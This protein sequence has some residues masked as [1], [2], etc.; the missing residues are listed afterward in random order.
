[1]IL[2]I[3]NFK[4]INNYFFT[5]YFTKHFELSYSV[6][7]YFSNRPRI[8]IS[9]IF[10][11]LIIK[12]PFRNKWTDE[13]DPPK[14]G[15]AIHHN[16]FWLYYGG[17]GNWG[18]NKSFAW[19]IPFITKNWYRTS[20]LLKNGNWEHEKRGKS[21]DFYH[22]KWNDVKMIYNYDFLDKYDNSVVP[23]EITVEER[24]WRP[25]WLEW[26]GLFKKVIKSI[27]VEFS[28]EVGS[29]KGS[30]KGGT[31]GCGYNMLPNEHPLDTIK[32]MEKERTF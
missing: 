27:N 32:R 23:C 30:W 3:K 2:S 8:T 24:E 6:C 5:F 16:T 28:K 9:L 12:L 20:L 19:D 18:G 1:M 11:T 31:I 29:R 22:S 14:Y 21:K 25:K 13:C 15:I 4:E 10:F 17:K 26:T 7:G